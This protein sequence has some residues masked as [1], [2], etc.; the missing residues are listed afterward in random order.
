MNVTMTKGGPIRSQQRHR[1]PDRAADPPAEYDREVDDVGAGQELAQR[2]G[3]VELLRGHPAALLDQ[4][5]PRPGQNPAEA[6]QRDEGEGDTKFEQRGCGRGWRRAEVGAKAWRPSRTWQR[7]KPAPRPEPNDIPAW[8]LLPRAARWDGAPG[9]RHWPGSR[10]RRWPGGR[11]G[12]AAPAA[13]CVRPCQA[14]FFVNLPRLYSW[15]RR[16]PDMAINGRR[17]KPIGPGG[18]T[19][20]LHHPG[21]SGQKPVIGRGA[22][23]GWPL[24][25]DP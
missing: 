3:V 24:I 20:R 19:R 12:C 11:V 25:T 23:D 18:S 10:M 4:H 21:V 8:W 2:V 13:A 9:H 6:A 17:N 5:A 22:S 7:L 15:C 14:S 1:R 16:K